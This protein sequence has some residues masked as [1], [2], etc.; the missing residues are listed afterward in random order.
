MVSVGGAVGDLKK[1]MEWNGALLSTVIP[2]AEGGG[3]KM[4]YAVNGN[5][6]SE[7]LIC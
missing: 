5:H 7:G 3:K 4:R 1:E 6:I 2:V